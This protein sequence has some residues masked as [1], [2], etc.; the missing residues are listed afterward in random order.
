MRTVA[1]VERPSSAT[2][3]VSN[4]SVPL[5][6]FNSFEQDR[7]LTEALGREGADWAEGRARD[8]GSVCGSA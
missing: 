3:E 7:P 4:Q 2:H 5:E 1:T 8:W 6:D